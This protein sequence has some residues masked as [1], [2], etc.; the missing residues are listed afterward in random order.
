MSSS[1][2]EIIDNL[3]NF[4]VGLVVQGNAGAVSLSADAE[5][6]SPEAVPSGGAPI[7][8]GLDCYGAHGH[9]RV[10]AGEVF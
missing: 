9:P 8:G 6:F 1:E 3:D 7:G 2:V 5:V 4:P 10:M